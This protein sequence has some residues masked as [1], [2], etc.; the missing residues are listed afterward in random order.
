M[1]WSDFLPLLRRKQVFEMRVRIDDLPEDTSFTTFQLETRD[2]PVIITN[3]DDMG[4]AVLEGTLEHML[5]CVYAVQSG[6]ASLTYVGNNYAGTPPETMKASLL[7]VGLGY[8]FHVTGIIQ[9]NAYGTERRRDHFDWHIARNINGLIAKLDDGAG[10]AELTTLWPERVRL[11][12]H[13]GAPSFPAG[14]ELVAAPLV[15]IYDALFEENLALDETKQVLGYLAADRVVNI[16][17]VATQREG[18]LVATGTSALRYAFIN[19]GR[20]SPRAAAFVER[21][22]PLLDELGSLSEMDVA[23]PY[24][25]C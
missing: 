20:L 5:S 3:L 1:E 17:P 8:L 4:S 10:I 15:P 19:G 24:Y 18:R 11:H 23:A 7:A 16:D 13:A 2:G 21:V 25:L 22:A 14:V 6:Q 12:G 9:A